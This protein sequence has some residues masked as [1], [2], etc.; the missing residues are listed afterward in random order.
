MINYN[1]KNVKTAMHLLAQK[2]A[3]EFPTD[4][5]VANIRFSAEFERKMD[6]AIKRIKK[7]LYSI[8]NTTAKRVAS[9]AIIL[10]ADV[11]VTPIP[12]RQYG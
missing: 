12:P 8:F 2:T 5:E 9:F 3:D 10:A 4:A 1:E 11:P 7:P 6:N